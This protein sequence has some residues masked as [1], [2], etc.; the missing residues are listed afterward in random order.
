MSNWFLAGAVVGFILLLF[1]LK[2]GATG[3]AY[4]SMAARGIAPAVPT[5]SCGCPGAAPP[6]SSGPTPANPNVYAPASSFGNYIV[7]PL[8][9]N[10]RQLF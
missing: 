6:T 9:V 7:G 8:G 4:V 10:L 5:S 3:A 2:R 1:K